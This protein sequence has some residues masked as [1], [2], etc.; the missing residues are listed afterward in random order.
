ML[1]GIVL[2]LWAAALAFAA[3]LPTESGD[4]FNFAF[5]GQAGAV[6]AYG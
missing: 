6:D 4:A 2:V 3:V 1:R 5:G